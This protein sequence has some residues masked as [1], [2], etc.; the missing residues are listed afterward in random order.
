MKA[1]TIS[2]AAAGLLLASLAVTAA[3][4][5]SV[6]QCRAWFDRIDSNNDGSV[7]NREGARRYLDKITLTST[8]TGGGG[9]STISRK[10]FLAECGVG[11][12]GMPNS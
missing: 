11:S 4:R 5:P 12:F 3:N 10:F 7:S 2:F 1:I 6:Q 8:A 9:D